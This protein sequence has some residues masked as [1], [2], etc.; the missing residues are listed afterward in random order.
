M[1]PEAVMLAQETVDQFVLIIVGS[2]LISIGSLAVLMISQCI[3][4]RRNAK[5]IR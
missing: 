1:N 3:R 2:A 4:D 5:R